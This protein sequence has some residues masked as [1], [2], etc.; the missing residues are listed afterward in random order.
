MMGGAPI[1]QFTSLATRATWLFLAVLT[2]ACSPLGPDKITEEVPVLQG[3]LGQFCLLFPV[4]ACI[5][6]LGACA[7]KA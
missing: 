2:P 7:G 1:F 5:N 4:L 6:R 3:F